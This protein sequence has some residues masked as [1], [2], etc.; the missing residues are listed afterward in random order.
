MKE[1]IYQFIL[2]SK[3]YCYA[4]HRELM[5]VI[6]ATWEAEIRRIVVQGQP[7]QIVQETP[8]LQIT[9]TK[10]TGSVAQVVECLLC[11]HTHTHTHIAA[12]PIKIGE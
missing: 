4:G 10:W 9:T 2:P 11:K 3:Y 12:T 6:L 1:I 5:T 7:R 8:H